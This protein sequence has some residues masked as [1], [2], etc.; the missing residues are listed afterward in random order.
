MLKARLAPLDELSKRLQDIYAGPIEDDLQPWLGEGV[1]VRLL[2]E[3]VVVAPR[4]QHIL[5]S[6][7]PPLQCHANALHPSLLGVRLASG[8]PWFGFSVVQGKWWCHS[9]WTDGDILV[10]SCPPAAPR[11]FWGLLWDVALFKALWP[12]EAIPDILMH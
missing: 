8:T 4:P 2:D 6:I 12:A 11:I 3:A 9:W 5:Y 7:G 1:Q 10:D